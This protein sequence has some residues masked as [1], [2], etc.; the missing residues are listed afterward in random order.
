MYN[1]NNNNNEKISETH[2]RSR[3]PNICRAPE[4]NSSTTR[5]LIH[6]LI[7]P[8]HEIA[9]SLQHHQSSTLLTQ[10]TLVAPNNSPV[11]SR[12]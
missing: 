11:S 9:T 1:S 5:E 6:R 3:S 4:Q 2:K 10:S 7:Q 12:Q 8:M